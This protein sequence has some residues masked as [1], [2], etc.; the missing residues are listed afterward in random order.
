MRKALI[1][2]VSAIAVIFTLWYMHFG[3]LTENSGALSVTGLSHP[4]Y[5]TIWGIL[6]FCGIFSNLFLAYKQLLPKYRFQNLLFA[7][8]A[9]GMILTLAFDFDYSLYVQYIL[10]CFGSLL[11]SVSTAAC[12]FL[13]FFLNFSKSKMFKIFTYIIGAVLIID[14]GM[15]LI[16][17]ETALIEAVPVLFALIILPVL[18][19]TSFFKEK[20][21]ASR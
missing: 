4:V 14:L 7:M 1:I 15:L 9:I 16:F 12:V 19:F 13:L 17:K 21:Y 6:A 3:S 8:S 5:F 11:F 2:A 20:E 18:N 10:H